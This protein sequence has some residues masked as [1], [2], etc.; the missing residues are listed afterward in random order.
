MLTR[1]D[2]DDPDI[3]SSGGPLTGISRSA[4]VETF[5]KEDIL[6]LQVRDSETG[7]ERGGKGGPEGEGKKTKRV[8]ESEK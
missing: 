6:S 7:E 4:Y 2:V 8:K 3:S 5:E 1:L